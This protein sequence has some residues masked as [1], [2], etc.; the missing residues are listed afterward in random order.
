MPQTTDNHF[1]FISHGL[2]SDTFTVVSFSGH[3]AISTPYRFE[4]LLS[5]KKPDIDLEKVIQNPATFTIRKNGAN[6]KDLPF[7]GILSTFEQLHQTRSAAFYRAELRPRL[8]WLTLTAHNQVF[9]N[10]SLEQL[11]TEMLQESG[12][13][14]GQDF[15]FRFREP[16]PPREFV[17]QYAESH[18]DFF[19]RWLE[20]DGSAYWFEQGEQAEKLIISDTRIAHTPL[21]GYETFFYAPP[22]GETS[23]HSGRIIQSFTLRQSHVPKTL[24]VKDYNYLKPSLDLS[25]QARIVEN[26]HGDIYLYGEHFLNKSDGERLARVRAE[27]YRCRQKSFH[28]ASVIPGIRPGYRFGMERH[29]RPDFN[30]DYLILSVRHEGGS[31]TGT[32]TDAMMTSGLFSSGA[33]SYRN[34]F[35][36]IP[37]DTQF[38]PERKTPKPR[39]AGT[40]S[41]RIDAAASG[42]YAELDEFG[43]YRVILPF[44]L[45]GRNGGKASAWIRMAT[46]Y[47]GDDCGLH[48]P[49]LKGTEVLLTFMDG[50]VDRPVIAHAVP[51]AETRSIVS[52]INSPA[53]AIRSAGGNQIVMGDKQGEEF[54]GIYSPFHDSGIVVGSHEPGGGGSIGI[55]TSGKYELFAIGAA[56]QAILGAKNSLTGG[57]VNDICAGLKSDLVAALRFSATLNKRMAY[58][59]GPEFYLGETLSELKQKISTMGAKSVIISGGY[60][61]D[62]NEQIDK[63]K[64]AI[65]EGIAGTAAAGL[66]IMG[67]S[68]PFDDHFLKKASMMWKNAAFFGGLAALLAGSWFSMEAAKEIETLIETLEGM[69]TSGSTAQMTFDANGAHITVNGNVSPDATFLAEIS[70]TDKKGQTL[71]ANIQLAADDEKT[72]TIQTYTKNEEDTS[73]GETEI[74][75][76]K[77][78]I[79]P[80]AIVLIRP[81]G[82]Q[83]TVDSN[84]VVLESLVPPEEAP[85]SEAEEPVAQAPGVISALANN[86]KLV[87]GDNYIE[88]TPEGINIGYTQ[89]VINGI[90]SVP[91]AGIQAVRAQHNIQL[92]SD[93]FIKLG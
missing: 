8:W 2:P 61:A 64:T 52:D 58:D 9:L 49:L 16:H 3:E 65:G 72:I 69:T 19:S 34:T 31:N 27:E 56:N 81:D 76:V 18:F 30:Q 73:S 68:A 70:R 37:S 89:L 12:L 51:N 6:Q 44:D 1:T 63:A 45:S 41:A 28:G 4:I 32:D 50:D 10:R 23:A 53:N 47:A 26:G 38:R 33:I 93:G 59:K 77:I 55:S 43:R 46:P 40:L 71:A 80:G 67:V 87:C 39:I 21:S 66:G 7:H 92:D 82:G 62:I 75:A 84:G 83:V 36:C 20:W 54:V 88:V 79:N 14:S 17:C 29:F 24:L 57:V 35:E 90:S 5:A 42:K 13:S 85:V 60:S 78:V 11:L 91:A 25:G 86:A 15:E 48:F 74:P 22:S